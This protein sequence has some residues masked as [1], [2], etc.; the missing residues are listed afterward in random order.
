MPPQT[1]THIFGSIN[2]AR[3]LPTIARF[4]GARGVEKFAA[5]ISG[6]LAD[7]KIMIPLDVTDRQLVEDFICFLCIDRK[8]QLAAFLSREMSAYSDEWKSLTTRSGKPLLPSRY[9]LIKSRQPL[10][11]FFAPLKGEADDGDS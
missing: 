5:D 7:D 9:A 4:F 1:L 2:R 8:N 6:S 3:I 10:P 11:P